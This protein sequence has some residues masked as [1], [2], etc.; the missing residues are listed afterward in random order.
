MNQ[1]L[2]L[3]QT[4]EAYKTLMADALLTTEEKSVITKELL[5]SLPP[6][7][8]VTQGKAA[9]EIITNHMAP[10]TEETLIDERPSGPTPAIESPMV[11]RGPQKQKEAAAKVISRGPR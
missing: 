9:R 2:S 7:M 10:K 1:L 3:L 11:T 5:E 4:Y 6:L 8:L